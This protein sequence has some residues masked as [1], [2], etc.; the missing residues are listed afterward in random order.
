MT[1]LELQLQLF[2]L[3]EK[4]LLLRLELYTRNRQRGVRREGATVCTSII[5][6]NLPTSQFYENTLLLFVG[7]SESKCSRI[8][9]VHAGCQLVLNWTHP[10][11]DERQISPDFCVLLDQVTGLD[12]SLLRR[13]QLLQL[14]T[15][16][17]NN[18]DM[19]LV[20]RKRRMGFTR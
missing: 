18:A 8:R 2:I 15:H 19:F 12:Q 5:A 6:T 10:E 1:E 3:F 4:R 14:R 16:T 9:L 11:A 13:I 7:R 17:N 20:I